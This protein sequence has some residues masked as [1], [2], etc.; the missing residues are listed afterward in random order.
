MKADVTTNI[1][2]YMSALGGREFCATEVGIIR[3][4]I[5]TEFSR[6]RRDH[7]TIAAKTKI[8]RAEIN[9]RVADIANFA[10]GIVEL[11]PEDIQL[12]KKCRLLEYADRTG[13]CAWGYTELRE[14]TGYDPVTG[15][16]LAEVGP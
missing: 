3:K 10:L 4:A 12:Y 8:G 5:R 7:R 9:R 6:R 16:E 11:S 1:A 15:R 14:R 13:K 2:E